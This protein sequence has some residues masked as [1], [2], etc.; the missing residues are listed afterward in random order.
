MNTQ[1]RNITFRDLYDY[2]NQCDVNQT[3]FHYPEGF[4]YPDGH[5]FWVL[6][7]YDKKD[8]V[9][10]NRVDSES[11]E[12]GDREGLSLCNIR[13]TSDIPGTIQS[14]KIYPCSRPGIC[15]YNAGKVYP[16]DSPIDGNDADDW[17]S[18]IIMGGEVKEVLRD[19]LYQFINK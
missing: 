10:I 14:V 3:G 17:Q 18:G 12:I 7:V 5:P 19:L 6:H 4:S 9:N 16:I 13:F 8:Q 2:I 15:D 1:E 11:K